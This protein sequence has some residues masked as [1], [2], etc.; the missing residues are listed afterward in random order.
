MSTSLIRRMKEIKGGSV[1]PLS[2]LFLT[3]EGI[4]YFDI[5]LFS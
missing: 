2:F 3:T 5:V 4:V 1:V